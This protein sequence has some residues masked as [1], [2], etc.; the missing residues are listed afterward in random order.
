MDPRIYI[1]GI[2]IVLG[3]SFG[4]GLVYTYK[5]AIAKSVQLE[6]DNAI[7]KEN[8]EKAVGRI[9]SIETSQENESQ[10]IARAEQA[11]KE[12]K[13]EAQKTATLFANHDFDNDLQ[14]KPEMVLS[15]VNAASGWVLT[16]IREAAKP[17]GAEA[18]LQESSSN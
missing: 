14:N 15:R 6:A 8:V 17:R 7:L 1:W 11:S 18:P 9:N 16:R 2:I 10:R 5:H 13:A 12:A 4:G 3:L